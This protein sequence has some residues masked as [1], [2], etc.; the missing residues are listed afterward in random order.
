MGFSPQDEYGGRASSR[1]PDQ[2]LFCEQ[3]DLGLHCL[4][5]PIYPKVWFCGGN[6]G[7]LK[8]LPRYS[9]IYL[10]L[11]SDYLNRILVDDFY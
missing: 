5:S 10:I 1:G 4:P 3:S 7:S 9:V 6:K 11:F 2:L 8:V